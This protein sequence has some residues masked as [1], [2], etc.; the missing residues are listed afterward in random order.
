MLL[1][2]AGPETITI[3]CNF[4]LRTRIRPFAHSLS[5]DVIYLCAPLVPIESSSKLEGLVASS[6]VLLFPLF[7]A[8]NGASVNI[9][10][11]PV[12]LIWFMRGVDVGGSYLLLAPSAAAAAAVADGAHRIIT[13]KVAHISLPV[14]HRSHTRRRRRRRRRIWKVG[15][16]AQ[17]RNQ[18]YKPRA[19][20]FQRLGRLVSSSCATCLTHRLED[21]Y[22]FRLSSSS[23]L[24]LF[25]SGA[26]A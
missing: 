12:L 4:S 25:H 16:R 19:S 22:A 8:R 24:L 1:C 26:P 17:W 18:N 10:H 6:L 21:K 14:A 11:T 2:F 13:I 5:A 20:C 15:Q 23:S 3:I 9:K 7:G